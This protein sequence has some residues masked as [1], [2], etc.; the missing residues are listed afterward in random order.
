MTLGRYEG[1]NTIVYCDKGAIESIA[2]RIRP[3]CHEPD[4]GGLPTAV[5]R[6]KIFDNAGGSYEGKFGE[7]HII[8]KD[9]NGNIIAEINL[10][11]LTALAVAGYKHLKEQGYGKSSR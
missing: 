3:D 5:L 10:A 6:G 4:E 9:R 11:D 8:Y 2:A 1:L 7:K